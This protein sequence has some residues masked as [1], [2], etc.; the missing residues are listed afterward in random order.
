[1][2]AEEEKDIFLAEEI[3]QKHLEKKGLKVFLKS[4][5]GVNEGKYVYILYSVLSL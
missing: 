5:I 2:Y 4:D 3:L 1:M